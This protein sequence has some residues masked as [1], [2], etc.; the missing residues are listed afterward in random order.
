M[1]TN[2]LSIILL[3]IED[4][5]RTNNAA[6]VFKLFQAPAILLCGKPLA[7]IKTL[8]EIATYYPRTS[9]GKFAISKANALT[10]RYLSRLQ[11]ADNTEISRSA[12]IKPF[13]SEREPGLLL[14]SFEQNLETILRLRSF[15]Q[16]S[17]QYRIIF[18]PTWQPF[19]TTAACLLAARSQ[20]PFF[21]MPSAFSEE[22]LCQ[23]FTPLCHFLPF[24]AASW[25]HGDFYDTPRSTKTI[26][27]LMVANFSKYKRH[28]KLFEALSALPPTLRV[29][30]A[31]P[32]WEGRTRNSLLGEARLFGV[33]KQITI[34]EGASDS[35]SLRLKGQPTI[36]E[37]LSK[38]RLFCA[39]SAKEGSYIAVAEALMA[40]TPVAMFR[41]AKIGTRAYINKET[42]FFLTK[43]RLLGPQLNEI[44]QRCGSINPQA[45]AKR[46]ISARANCKRLNALL[47]RWSEDHGLGWSNGIEPFFSRHFVFEYMDPEAEE[48]LEPEYRRVKDQFGLSIRRN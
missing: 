34:V 47:R 2:H 46:N 7:R 10:K 11:Q 48:R 17:A 21:I 14:V 39:M 20:E 35:P 16:F 27:I 19:Y 25:V 26:D 42:G 1:I 24:H 44:L 4:F 5:L 31:G 37:L 38:S 36:R 43:D 3:H 28:W 41:T 30:L 32:S 29:T 15:A 45:W 33:E 40:G 6:G 8:I 23:K 22:D 12:I 13:V 9:I 18:L